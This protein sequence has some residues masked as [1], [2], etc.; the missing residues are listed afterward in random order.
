MITLITCLLIIAGLLFLYALVGLQRAE[1]RNRAALRLS[2]LIADDHSRRYT[3][4]EAAELNNTRWDG[5]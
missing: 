2:A 4:A 5:D 1:R 3:E